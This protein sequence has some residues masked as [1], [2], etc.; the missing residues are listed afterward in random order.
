MNFIRNRNFRAGPQTSLEGF[1]CPQNSDKQQK[2][3]VFGRSGGGATA[4]EVKAYLDRTF[5]VYEQLYGIHIKP[6][7]SLGNRFDL[8]IKTAY[9]QTGL[10]VAIL[11]DEYDSPLQHSWKTP[12]HEGCT[13]VYRSVFSILK[14]D[15]AYQRFVFITGITKFTQISLF[16]TFLDH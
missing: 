11:I 12:E 8:I 6:T 9:E 3:K 13:E 1:I 4:N 10:K 14:A 2:I 5:D 7:D 16:S 15:D